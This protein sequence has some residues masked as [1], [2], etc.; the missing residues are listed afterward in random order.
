VNVGEGGTVGRSLVDERLSD[1]LVSDAS[2]SREAGVAEGEDETE[3]GDVDKS[4]SNEGEDEVHPPRLLPCTHQGKARYW[5]H[6]HILS[7][8]M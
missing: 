4:I 3:E 1:V 7:S 2:S 8:H 6:F 5:P